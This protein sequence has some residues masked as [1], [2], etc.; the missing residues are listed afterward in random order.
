V[1]SVVNG[2]PENPGKESG[3]RTVNMAP[4]EGCGFGSEWITINFGSWAWIRIRIR[5]KKLDP[6]PQFKVK[7]Q[8]LYRLKIEP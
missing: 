2:V 8:K 7:N 5:A 4:K 1:T 3:S 6:Y